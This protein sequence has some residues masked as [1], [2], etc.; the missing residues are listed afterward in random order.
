MLCLFFN[1]YVCFKDVSGKKFNCERFIFKSNFMNNSEGNITSSSQINEIK[2][3]KLTQRIANRKKNG[4]K[5]Y[6]KNLNFF[7]F[8]FFFIRKFSEY[9]I[10]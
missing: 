2:P 10:K 7:H 6:K 4:K 3:L 1:F 5:I 8:L 9:S